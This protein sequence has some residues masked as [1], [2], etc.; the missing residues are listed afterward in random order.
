MFIEGNAAAKGN[1]HIRIQLSPDGRSYQLK[2]FDIIIENFK[3]QKSHEKT[4]TLNHF[5]RQA[6]RISY[7]SNNKLVLNATYYYIK[8][9]TNTFVSNGTVGI[10]LNPKGIDV[11]YVK[12]DGNPAE[13]KHYSIGNLLDKRSKDT[14]RHLSLL[15]DKIIQEAFEAGFYHFTIED[16]S[17][18][19][20]YKYRTKELNR[21]LSKFPFRMFQQL[22]VSKLARLGGKLR[23]IN[24]AYTTF[25]GLVKY[26][27]RDNKTTNHNKDSEDLSAALVIGRRGLGFDE[28]LVVC[29]R[30][31]GRQISLT[32]PEILKLLGHSEKYLSKKDKSTLKF[33]NWVLWKKIKLEFKTYDNLVN[34]LT[35]RLEA[36]EENVLPF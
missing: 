35:A 6:M 32:L 30:Y 12:N 13:Y 15:I 20:D 18:A 33:G 24:P 2:I 22:L 19:E 7:N 1:R 26:A 8:P 3:I 4:F 14:Q 25:I 29:F 27:V 28:K 9:I 34:E 36:E 16:L 31:K 5:N 17:F 10:D 21:L 11:C 23:Q